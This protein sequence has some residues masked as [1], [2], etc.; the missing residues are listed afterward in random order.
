MN[1]VVFIYI[2]CAISAFSCDSKLDR[3][4]KSNPNLS[5]FYSEYDSDKQKRKSL[6]FLVA[7]ATDYDIG[8]LHIDSLKV[9]IDLA[10][11]RWTSVDWGK[12][13]DQDLF[14]E[15]VLPMRVS[16]EPLEYYWR[17]DILKKIAI[18]GD[19]KDVRSVAEQINKQIKINMSL[20]LRQ[21]SLLGYKKTIQGDYGK[22]DDRAVLTTMALRAYGVPAAFDYVPYWGNTNSGHSV[23]S[24]ILPNDSIILFQSHSNAPSDRELNYK[25][26]KVYRRTYTLQGGSSIF[27]Y[28]KRESVPPIFSQHRFI[29]V[30]SQ[31]AIGVTDVTVEIDVL[32]KNKLLYLSVFSPNNWQAI[33]YAKRQGNVATFFDIGT[34]VNDIGESP[35]KC[36]NIGDGILYLPCFYDNGDIIPAANPIIVSESGIRSI[37]C[38]N[39]NRETIILHRKYPLR[40]RIIAYA[41]E[42]KGGRIEGANTSDFSDSKELHYIFQTPESRLQHVDIESDIPFKYIR[43]YKPSGVF[44]IAELRALDAKQNIIKGSKF[45]MPLL[46]DVSDLDNITDGDALT[47]YSLSGIVN[48]WSGLEFAKP[49]KIRHIEFAPRND[50]NAISPGDMYELFYWDGEWMSLGR[51]VATQYTLKYDNVPKGALLWLRNITRGREERPFTYENDCQIWW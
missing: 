8:L 3:I 37:K 18:D 4:V 7:N 11:D 23:C 48:V 40:Q 27:K 9:N 49:S 32:H 46:K 10:Y 25:T 6:H 51:K 1:K 42:M 45:T 5:T 31:H 19:S 20:N 14:Q 24:A 38:D 34:G 13:Y 50:D 35:S 47:Y 30:T 22:C 17:S 26:P 36:K 43:Y 15:Y 2:I 29:D 33:A 41:D 39:Q 44:S 16:N 28:G 12:S 21:S